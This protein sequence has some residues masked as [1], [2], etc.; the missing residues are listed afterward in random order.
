MLKQ[1]LVIQAILKLLSLQVGRGRCCCSMRS[2]ACMRVGRV[3]HATCTRHMR[4]QDLCTAA[5]VCKAWEREADSDTFWQHVSFQGRPV[6]QPTLRALVARH[7]RIE[8][9]DMEGVQLPV[10]VASASSSQL[11]SGSQLT[12]RMLLGVLPKLTR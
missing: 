12:A 1:P 3:G 5:T 10:N 6:S 11:T 9:L 8:T 4:L 7:P 2:A